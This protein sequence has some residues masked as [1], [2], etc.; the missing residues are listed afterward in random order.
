MLNCWYCF[1]VFNSVRCFKITCDQKIIFILYT[2]TANP[3]YLINKDIWNHHLSRTR[4]YI[5]GYIKWTTDPKFFFPN[6]IR[7]RILK[8]K[9]RTNDL[10]QPQINEDILCPNWHYTLYS[11]RKNFWFNEHARTIISRYWLPSNNEKLTF[12]F[13]IYA[14]SIS[15]GRFSVTKNKIQIIKPRYHASKMI[16]FFQLFGIFL[17]LKINGY[18][19]I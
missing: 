14:H 3:Y 7:Q 13:S 5:N 12:V 4:V 2:N 10:S 15:F 11:V 16:I 9:I 6:L 18:Y 17:F 1:G 8:M 19:R